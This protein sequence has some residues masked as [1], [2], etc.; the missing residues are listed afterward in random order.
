MYERIQNEVYD[1][2][3]L[4]QFDSKNLAHKRIFPSSVVLQNVVIIDNIVVFVRHSLS[5]SI[6][7]CTGIF[8]IRRPDKTLKKD[9][10]RHT[11]APIFF[12]HCICA[13]CLCIS[14]FE[15]PSSS[16]YFVHSYIA[17]VSFLFLLWL[18]TLLF[19]VVEASLSF[20]YHFSTSRINLCNTPVR[21]VV[22]SF[23]QFDI[24]THS[25]V[26][27]RLVY[28]F[29]FFLSRLQLHRPLLLCTALSPLADFIIR[30]LLLFNAVNIRDWNGAA[31]AAAVAATGVFV[32]IE[33][34]R[35]CVI[36]QIHT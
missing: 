23:V 25:C 20:V 18:A 36:L 19:D 1:G 34:F 9:E 30:K 7:S 31:A 13:K 5:L 28:S 26:C 29:F 17:T 6:K 10:K 4:S 22:R 33:L 35:H 8:A 32:H 21:S 27:A 16:V 11:V 12:V 2:L 24:F 14:G 3:T 15:S